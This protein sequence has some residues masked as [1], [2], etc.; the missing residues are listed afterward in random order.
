MSI[1]FEVLK[2][3]FFA[4][5]IILW[6]FK[7]RA[8]AIWWVEGNPLWVY[9]TV[10]EQSL[11]PGY[12]LLCGLMLGYIIAQIWI[13]NREDDSKGNTTIYIQSFLIGL[14]FGILLA[15]VWIMI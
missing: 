1:L 6:A 11:M 12:L 9:K 2:I 5:T 4:M 15:I 10:I 3:L 13:N 8:E 14:I 7:L